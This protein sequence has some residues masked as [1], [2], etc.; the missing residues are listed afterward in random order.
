MELYDFECG[1][2]VIKFMEI[3]DHGD[4]GIGNS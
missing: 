1:R 3:E 4:V 2:F